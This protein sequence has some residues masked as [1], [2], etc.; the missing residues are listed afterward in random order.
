MSNLA[1]TAIDYSPVTARDI[2][3]VFF[4]YKLQ[5]LLIFVASLLF[6][7][8][9]LLYVGP[10]Y[11]AQ[12]KILVLIGKEKSSA[13]DAYSG[14][15]NVIFSE[16]GQN[17]N[18]EIEILNDKNMTYEVMPALQEYLEA[19]YTEPT[20]LLQRIKKWFRI[21]FRQL[22]E[23][24]RTPFYKLGVMVKLSAIEQLAL[25]FQAALNVEFIEETDLIMLSFRWPDPNFAAF[26]ANAYADAYVKRRIV[27]HDTASSE[28]FYLDQIRIYEDQLS[29]VERE[30]EKFRQDMQISSI[31]IQKD[32]LLREISE[33]EKDY[34]VVNTTLNDLK[35]KLDTIR[36]IYNDTDE[37]IETPKI[38]GTMPDLT[39]L[40]KYFFD[41]MAER[42]RLLRSHTENSREVINT[43]G[44][45]AK[46][47]KQKLESLTNFISP[48][49]E[50]A[51]REQRTIEEKQRSK[52]HALYALDRSERRL[53]ELERTRNIA[54]T[55][56]LKYKEKAEDFRIS[57]ELNARQITSV[58]IIGKALPPEKPSAP[59]VTLVM[60]LAAFLGLFLGF[61]YSVISEFFDHSFRH[62]DDV[63]AILG[64]PLLASIPDI[65]RYPNR[66]TRFNGE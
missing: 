58:R 45:I 11:S 50:S 61:A 65:K 48:L 16:R 14:N 31:D 34:R 10:T 12:T 49:I 33:L 35:I 22:K 28:Q 15:P 27:I 6:S 30:L 64:I 52:K 56:Y 19:S 9:Y 13:I 32:L 57:E 54:E 21:K 18:N 40:D 23:L 17:I 59:W 44:Q 53:K 62:K 51:R 46:L 43:S 39:E 41:I 20:T 8:G 2:L 36:S 55:N 1:G 37:W 7:L 42:D 60:A 3:Y 25:S 66:G 63:E 24:I 47:R 38:T 4:K 26:A 29:G 5:I